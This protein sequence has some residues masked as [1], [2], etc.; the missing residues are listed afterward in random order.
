MSSV[1][2]L[3]LECY[4]LQNFKSWSVYM[5]LSDKVTFGLRNYF[6]ILYCVH[7]SL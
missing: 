2:Q 5:V 7:L 4:P 6:L 3:V 1:S